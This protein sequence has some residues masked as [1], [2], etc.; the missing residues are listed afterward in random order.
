M[1]CHYYHFYIHKSNL[2]RRRLITCGVSTVLFWQSDM[3]VSISVYG[4][5]VYHTK[6]IYLG[7]LS[8]ISFKHLHA[9]LMS[10][11]TTSISTNQSTLYDEPTHE[12][13]AQTFNLNSCKSL[14][15]ICMGF[16]LTVDQGVGLLVFTPDKPNGEM[17]SMTIVQFNS[18]YKFFVA[19]YSVDEISRYWCDPTCLVIRLSLRILVSVF[20]FL[21]IAALKI[22]CRMHDVTIG[23]VRKDDIIELLSN[24]L[25]GVSCGEPYYVFR[26]LPKERLHILS[27]F[28]QSL[29]TTVDR[30]CPLVTVTLPV[31]TSGQHQCSLVKDNQIQSI[32]NGGN[33]I[34]PIDSGVDYLEPLSR[35]RAAAIIREWQHDM[36]I[37]DMH[38]YV[39][40]ACSKK[41]GSTDSHYIEGN[42][43]DLTLLRNDSLPEKII[44]NSYDLNVYKRVILNVKGLEDPWTLRRIRLCRKCRSSLRG[45]KMPKFAL[46][47]WLYYGYDRLPAAVKDAFD[48]ASLFDRMLVCRA[49]CNSICCRFNVDGDDTFVTTASDS[50]NVLLNSR[51][52]VRGNVMVAPLDTLKMNEALP[53]S[54]RALRDTMCALF[55]GRSLPNRLNVHKYQPVLVRKSRVKTMIQFLLANNKHYS[56]QENIH[57]DQKNL[58]AL[59]DGNED[60]GVPAVAELGQVKMTGAIENLTSDYTPRNIDSSTICDLEDEIMI[61]NVG[62]TDGDHSPVNYREMKA[63][64]LERCL[65]GKPFIASGIGSQLIP[66]FYHPSILTWL[67]PHLDPWG[68]GGFHHPNRKIKI[69]MEEQLSHLMLI[70]N[71]PFEKDNEFAFVFHNVIRKAQV[72]SSLQFRVPFRTHQRIVRELLSVDP[73]TLNVM[74]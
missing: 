10:S 45:S 35:C 7:H 60:V 54:S 29:S 66:D 51:K 26:C 4:G 22:L 39:C 38:Q 46:C 42:S 1:F 33:D 49:R 43:I 12:T 53:P 50:R 16:V 41:V 58:E 3:V 2:D 47:N 52:G 11:S 23:R 72:S 74:S 73:V 71:S 34:E 6:G 20:R 32:F 64:A 48:T 37:D 56:E 31:S 62:Y 65:L 44:P 18:W 19:V 57:F 67:F 13:N 8:F 25:C 21:S 5:D 24:H 61:E 17:R 55:V 30:D 15:A 63:L 70:D 69:S 27:Y 28:G 36:K 14:G 9:M 59:F 40:A 68:L